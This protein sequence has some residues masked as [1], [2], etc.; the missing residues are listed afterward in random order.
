MFCGGSLIDKK[1]VLSAAH[2][3]KSTSTT[4]YYQLEV[5]LGN[6][7]TKSNEPGEVNVDVDKIFKHE[8]YNPS[9]SDYDMAL[10]RLKNPVT[11]SDYVKQI[12]LP[13]SDKNFLDCT[14][15]KNKCACIVT[16]FGVTSQ[17]G[18]QPQDLMKVEV[19]IMTHEECAKD[20]H[21][22]LTDRMIC[23]GYKEGGKDSCQGDSGGPLVCSW[24]NEKK[25]Y[26]AGVVSYGYG[27]ALSGYPGVYADVKN[28]KGWIENTKSQNS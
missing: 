20:N 2:C 21:Y 15:G 6:T 17:G 3:F 27:C 1:W 26:L 16:G 9:T 19:P 28:L 24:C 8:Q 10:V 22:R 4:G 23:A 7:K 5:V 11:Y 12:C 13:S 14:K 18:S 25:W